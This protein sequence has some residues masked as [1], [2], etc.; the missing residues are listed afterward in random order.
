MPKP[1]DIMGLGPERVERLNTDGTWTITVTPPKWTGFKASSVII[2]DDEF[3][4]YRRWMAG[5][6]KIQDAL[7]NLT[8]AQREILLS[9]I[10]PEA[11]DEAFSDKGK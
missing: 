2:T 6:V 10:G 8:P 4:Q 7:P 9:G 1:V 3:C 5:L 11:W